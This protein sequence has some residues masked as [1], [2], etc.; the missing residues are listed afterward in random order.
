M[1]TPFVD[2]PVSEVILPKLQICFFPARN[3]TSY[4]IKKGETMDKFGTLVIAMSMV[5]GCVTAQASDLATKTY[6]KFVDKNGGILLPRDDYRRDWAHLGSWVVEES[7]APGYGFHDV[8]A[9]PEAVTAYRKTGKF[10]D[11]TVL[12]KEIRAVQAGT[13]TSGKALWAGSPNIWFVMIKDDKRRFAGNPHWAEGWGWALYEVKD[14][15]VNVSKGFK[16]TCMG[17]HVPAKK[18]DWVFIEGYPTLNKH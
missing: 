3:D 17:C 12:I 9:Q 7:K 14:P 5:L 8:Y 4:K 1:L 18:T 16:E 13:M 10:P 11:G 6:L 15:K 2:S